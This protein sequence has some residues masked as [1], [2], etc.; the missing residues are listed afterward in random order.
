[1]PYRLGARA[2]AVFSYRL[3][4]QLAGL[5]THTQH[6]CQTFRPPPKST[7][8]SAIG[9]TRSYTFSI[10]H[11]GALVFPRAPLWPHELLIIPTRSHALLTVLSTHVLCVRYVV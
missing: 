3:V 11:A 5:V 9:Q 8:V 7:A 2:A 6:A 4:T 10:N 1:M